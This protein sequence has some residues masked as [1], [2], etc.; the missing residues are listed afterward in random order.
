[1]ATKYWKCSSQNKI[2]L[3]KNEDNDEHF[4]ILTK[5]V[6][7]FWWALIKNISFYENVLKK[8]AKTLAKK[9]LGKLHQLFSTTIILSSH[10]TKLSWQVW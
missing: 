7:T 5:Y 2:I 1:M 6:L 10:Q 8:L 4:G 9:G 3:V